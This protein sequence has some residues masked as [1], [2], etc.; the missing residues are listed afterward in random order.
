MNEIKAS[1]L[2]SIGLTDLIEKLPVAVKAHGKTVGEIYR[3]TSQVCK[4]SLVYSEF[5]KKS[6]ACKSK[7]IG[8]SDGLKI[9]TRKGNLI[10][11]KIAQLS[12]IY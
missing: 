3:H 1:E 4:S 12:R 6:A 11:I 5:K 10:Y 7:L 8:R 2:V 9:I